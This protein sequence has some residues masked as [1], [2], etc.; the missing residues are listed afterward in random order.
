MEMRID[1]Y[2][3][4]PKEQDFICKY[5]PHACCL[6]FL[7]IAGIMAVLIYFIYWIITKLL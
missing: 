5:A 2:D 3:E 6:A 4:T 7:L 1:T